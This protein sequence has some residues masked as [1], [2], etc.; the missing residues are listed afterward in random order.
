MRPM[1]SIRDH[2]IQGHSESIVLVSERDKQ[3]RRYLWAAAHVLESVLE[4]YFER[5]QF[6][7]NQIELEG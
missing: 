6:L 7:S 4:L 3:C 2:A 1:A 5:L